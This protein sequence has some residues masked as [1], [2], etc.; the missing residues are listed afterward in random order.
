MEK[1]DKEK[2]LTYNERNCILYRQGEKIILHFLL[3]C[4]ERFLKLF[5]MNQKDAK[6]ETNSWKDFADPCDNYFK[7]TVL[8]LLANPQGI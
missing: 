3:T 4:S 5:T 8:P 7:Q 6:K 2:T 1:D